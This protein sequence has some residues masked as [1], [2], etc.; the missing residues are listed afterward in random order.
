MKNGLVNVIVCLG[1]LILGGLPSVAQASPGVDFSLQPP[2][3]IVDTGEIFAV[4]I[5]VDASTQEV[6]IV[7]AYIDYDTNYLKVVDENGNVIEGIAD[8]IIL[9]GE[10]TTI[11]LTAKLRNRVDNDSGYADIT[12][13]MPPGGTPASEVFV[14]GTIRFKVTA[15]TTS[16][17]LTFHTTAL[18]TTMA[19]RS[20]TDVTGERLAAS[21]ITPSTDD[22]TTTNDVGGST[23]GTETPT[24]P[25]ARPINWPV[26]WWV[27]SGVVAVTLLIF[28]LVR[29]SS[30]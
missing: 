18:R 4:D 6:D 14:L 11:T 28:L 13:G 3:Q 29:R 23:N 8:N 30:Y 5:Q 26:L 27:I 10:I 25:Q 1:I 9:P 21:I 16:T 7:E 15:K 22:Y 17:V 19:V 20:F 24:S 2:S 12:Y